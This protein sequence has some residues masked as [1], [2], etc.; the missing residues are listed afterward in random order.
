MV[1]KDEMKDDSHPIILHDYPSQYVIDGLES[2]QT[3]IQLTKI[4]RIFHFR[5]Y[6]LVVSNQRLT[7]EIDKKVA[8]TQIFRAPVFLQLL[9]TPLL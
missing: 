5:R 3:A 9:P 2:I 6:I 8:E 1:W 4:P 7:F